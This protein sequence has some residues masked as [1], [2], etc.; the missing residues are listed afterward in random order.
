MPLKR[1]AMGSEQMAI[2]PVEGDNAVSGLHQRRRQ[3][4]APSRAGT[5]VYLDAGASI[6]AALARVAGA[7]G[8]IHTPKTALPPGMGFFAHHRGQRGRR[9]GPACA[10]MSRS[11]A[12]E[13]LGA[14][15]HE[16]HPTR[17]FDPWSRA[18]AAPR[19]L[20]APGAHLQNAS[21]CSALRWATGWA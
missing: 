21:T 16:Q 14:P 2:F 20:E 6:D 19:G 8:R 7:G 1:E 9:G 5:R 13:T 15:P 11:I 3:G 12:P 17:H 4:V 18:D 10:A